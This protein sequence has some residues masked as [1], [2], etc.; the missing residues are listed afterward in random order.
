MIC[1][2]AL[3]AELIVTYFLKV[4]PA[5]NTA[6]KIKMFLMLFAMFYKSVTAC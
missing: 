3:Q 5:F 1:R 6:R 4:L 2:H